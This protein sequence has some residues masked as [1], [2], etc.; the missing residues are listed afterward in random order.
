M[1]IKKENFS[2]KKTDRTGTNMKDI[3]KMEDFK[4]MVF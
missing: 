4:E 3:L 2:L 1:G